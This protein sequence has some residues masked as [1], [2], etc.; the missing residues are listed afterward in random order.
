MAVLNLYQMRIAA[1]ECAW[2]ES[3]YTWTVSFEECQHVVPCCDKHQSEYFLG[4]GWEQYYESP[5][6][7]QLTCPDCSG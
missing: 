1:G 4:V 3:Q 7:F 2:C 5:E 6:D